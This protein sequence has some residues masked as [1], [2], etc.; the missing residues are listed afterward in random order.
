M[1]MSEHGNAVMQTSVNV[2]AK[3]DPTL[4]WF[5]GLRGKL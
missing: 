1:G 5:P 3:V 4:V 2:A